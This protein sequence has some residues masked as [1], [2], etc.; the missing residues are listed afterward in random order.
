M[1]R[2]S[3]RVCYDVLVADPAG[4]K[5]RQ[6]RLWRATGYLAMLNRLRVPQVPPCLNLRYAQSV[7]FKLPAQDAHIGL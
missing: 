6:R 7:E 3:L 1:I 2:L 4:R 5:Q